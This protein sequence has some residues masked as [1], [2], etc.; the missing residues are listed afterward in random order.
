MPERIF[1][2]TSAWVA[3]YIPKDAHHGEATAVLEDLQRQSAQFV[4][5]NYVIAE[6][7]TAVRR[8]ASHARATALGEALLGS[9]V[10][11][12]VYLDERLEQAAWALFKKYNDRAFSFTDCTSFALMEAEGLKRVFAFDRDFRVAGFQ[13]LP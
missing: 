5:S 9:R 2:D 1:V 12:R 6:A 7:I 3:L 4:I 10:L 11:R 13:V 8:L